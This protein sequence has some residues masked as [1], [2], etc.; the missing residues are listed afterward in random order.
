M[1]KLPIRKGLILFILSSMASCLLFSCVSPITTPKTVEQDLTGAADKVEV[2]YFHRHR[3]CEAC[4]YAEER[5]K[6]L[7]TTNY[8]EELANG[9]M[10]FGIYDIEDKDS[11]VLAKK[12]GAIGSQ[13]FLNRIKDGGENIRYIEEIWYWG[14]IDNEEVFDRTVK[15]VIDKALHGIVKQ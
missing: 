7:V 6:Y 1:I 11:D 12:Y 4:T 10:S 13:L 3:R 5:I 8:R 15:D 2:V 9:Q 14:C